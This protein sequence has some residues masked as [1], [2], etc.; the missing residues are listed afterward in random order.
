MYYPFGF[1]INPF[2]SLQLVEH[3]SGLFNRK[4]AKLAGITLKYMVS[5]RFHHIFITGV[6]FN[7]IMDLEINYVTPR[8]RPMIPEKVSEV[9][10]NKT[11]LVAEDEARIRR[12]LKDFLT[13]CNYQVIEAEDGIKALDLFYSNSNKIDLLLLDVMMPNKDGFEVLKEIR[14][15]SLTPVIMLT[16][17]SQE[18]DQLLGFRSGADDYVTKPFSPVLLLAHIEAVLKRCRNSTEDNIKAGG[19]TIDKVGMNVKAEDRRICLTPKEYDLLL[20]FIDN[21]D[22]V[23]SR[24]QILN[25]VWNYDYLGDSRTVDTHI[26]QLRSKIGNEYI[27]TIHG[28]GYRFEVSTCSVQ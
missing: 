23:L 17:K 9:M 5:F 18:Y 7:K 26:K 1:Y 15:I 25:K 13:S 19:L 12:M 20:Y 3:K 8:Y 16:A 14:E 6:M 28:R 2:L 11:I 22:I 21:Q 4:L 10:N 24:E 27:R